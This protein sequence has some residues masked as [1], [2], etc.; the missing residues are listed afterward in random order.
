MFCLHACMYGLYVYIFVEVRTRNGVTGHCESTYG[1]WE[2]NSCPL[3]G[4]CSEQ[5]S[6]L[7]THNGDFINDI[8]CMASEKDR[9]AD[10]I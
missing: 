7:P 4:Q 9:K 6:H 2:L 1:C 10:E 8:N 5:L 3:Q